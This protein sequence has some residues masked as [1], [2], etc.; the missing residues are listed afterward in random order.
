MLVV[1]S[2]A[3]TPSA[4][5]QWPQPP[6]APKISVALFK[7]KV[8]G[9][10]LFQ[11]YPLF[12]LNAL[13]QLVLFVTR[14]YRSAGGWLNDKLVDLFLN[15]AVSF[16]LG[17]PP[18]VSPSLLHNPCCKTTPLMKRFLRILTPMMFSSQGGIP[19]SHKLADF[20]A[21]WDYCFRWHHEKQMAEKVLGPWPSSSR[22]C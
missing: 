4:T 13:L 17:R 6:T 9:P 2:P 16:L 15:M 21:E 1:G 22:Q 18:P 12:Q 3:P 19:L 11:T 10:L 7:V 5:T 14:G 20:I 8:K